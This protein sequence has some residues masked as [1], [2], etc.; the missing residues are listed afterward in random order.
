MPN[1]CRGTLKVRGT[2]KNLIEFILQGLHPVNYFGDKKEP[3]KIDEDEYITSQCECWIEGT[4]RGFTENLDLYLGNLSEDNQEII[5]LDSEFAWGIEAQELLKTCKKYNV[6]MRIYAFE[7]GMGF[8]QE[9][10]IVDGKITIDKYIKFDNYQW[11]CSM[12]DIGG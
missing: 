6:D 5:F 1:W 2:K 12:P 11:E 10:E 9:I 4:T 3:L 8:N 7:R